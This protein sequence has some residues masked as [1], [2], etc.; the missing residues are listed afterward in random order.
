VAGQCPH[1]GAV[2]AEYDEGGE[3]CVPHGD[4]A[5]EQFLSEIIGA[6][7]FAYAALRK[8]R[9]CYLGDNRHSDSDHARQA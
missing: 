1:R 4:K 2:P 3:N 9:F 8:S 6:P 7:A 5:S